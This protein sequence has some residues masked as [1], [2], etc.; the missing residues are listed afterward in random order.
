MKF[1]IAMMKHETNT[2]SPVVTD[3]LRFEEWG[4]YFGN[5]AL[6][7]YE[8]TGMP[9]AA[10][11]DI[12]RENR[13]NIVTPLAA[14]AMPSGPVTSEAYN[15]MVD[16]IC[17]AVDVGCDA[18]LLDL[19]GAMV[20]ETTLDG[21]GTL[22]EKIRR[23]NPTLPIAVTCDFHCNLTQ[24]MVDNCTALIGYK[25]YPHVDMYQVGKQVGRI[26]IDS[27]QGK[28][29]PV[30][31]R[32]QLPLLTHTLKQGTDDYPMKSLIQ[33]CKDAEKDNSVLA[34]TL[35]GGFPLADMPDAGASVIVVTDGD[36]A[37][38]SQISRQI[39]DKTWKSR[40]DFIYQF[41]SL[42]ETFARAK[43]LTE[44]PV[45]LLDHEDNCG[46]GGTQD[47]M[48]VIKEVMD[49]NLEDVAVAAVYDPEAV[50]VMQ[51]AG[52]GAE[53]EI[54]LGGKIDMPSISLERKPLLLRGKVKV[55]TDGHWTVQGPMYTGVE[56]HMGPTAVFDTGNVEIVVVSRHHEPWDVGVFT[57]VGIQPQQKKYLLLKSR[58]HYRAGF[59]P[60][61]KQTL[62]CDGEGV[63]TSRNDLLNY[64]HLR[65]PIFPLD[66]GVEF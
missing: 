57:S 27:M 49:Q 48:A 24:K 28:C 13:A 58:I 12:A 15:R 41:G 53:V 39:A 63:T 25:T 9:M 7:A 10:Y 4:A 64:R 23:I 56:V 20:S 62:H 3:W 40:E 19:H 52:I 31:A 44:Y 34:A 21:E 22:L 38:A 50:K 1:V 55:L 59:A 18:V 47:V 33:A 46:S 36:Q 14:E 60:I 17:E 45:I 2:F 8:N 11:I 54:S 61:T 16:A 35:F 42:K 6:E 29:S 65:R 30:M 43:Q 37:K 5:A 51:E 66:E 32:L 26:V